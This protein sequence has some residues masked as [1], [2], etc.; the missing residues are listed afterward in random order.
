MMVTRVGINGFGRIGRLVLRATLALYPDKLEVAA[1]NDLTDAKTNAHLF[2]YDTNYGVYPGQ[3]EAHNSDLMVDGRSIRVF[4]QRDPAQIPWSELGVDLVVES[5]GI[6]TDAEKAA[7][8]FKG[9]ARKVIISAPARGEDLTLVLGVN[10]HVYDAAKHHI[11]S[12]ASCTTNCFAPMVKVLHEAFGIEHGLMSTI[13]S[14][15][16]D[17][18]ILDQRHPDLRRARAA[19]MN[20]IPT[21]TGAARAV[22]VVLPELNGKLHGIAFRV[23][24]ATGSVTDFVANVSRDVTVEEVNRAFKEAAAGRLKGILEYTD[25]PLVSSDF[26][27]NPH[28]CIFDALSTIVMQKRMVKV[29]GWYDNEWGYSCRTADLCAFMA[30]KGI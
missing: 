19:A 3:V 14:Y 12:N 23:P 30:D 5:T 2:K 18:A 22:G 29:M 15:T 13:H 7:G 20:I 10:D 9:G 21:S 6:F 4:S 11:V 28:S 25:E 17:Q 1:V 8:H 26:K 24:T 16:N 27:G